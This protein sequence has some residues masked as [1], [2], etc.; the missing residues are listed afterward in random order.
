MSADGPRTSPLAVL[1]VCTAT[2][3]VT[4]P[5]LTKE[6]LKSWRKQ[7]KAYQF[8]APPPSCLEIVYLLYAK[9]F[10]FSL[11]YLL[12]NLV[13]KF[14]STTATLSIGCIEN[15]PEISDAADV[16]AKAPFFT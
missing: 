9:S 3:V 7:A 13:P 14:G 6:S 2:I 8:V 15:G 16:I 5:D 11:A 12:S 10:N 1:D 4:S